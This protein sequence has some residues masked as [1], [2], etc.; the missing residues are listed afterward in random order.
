M[1]VAVAVAVVV[2]AV[3]VA[4]VIFAV[5]TAVVRNR[6]LAWQLMVMWQHGQFGY[7]LSA[8]TTNTAATTTKTAATT[9]ITITTT[10]STI[11]VLQLFSCCCAHFYLQQLVFTHHQSMTEKLSKLTVVL[12]FVIQIPTMKLVALPL[13]KRRSS[14]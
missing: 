9:R 14:C 6:L 10:T 3:A 1:A 7:L 5:V 11:T 4:V 8:T 12:S 13:A 2:V